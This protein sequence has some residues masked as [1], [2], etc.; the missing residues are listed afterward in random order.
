MQAHIFCYYYSNSRG[1]AD[2]TLLGSRTQTHS[3]PS[4]LSSGHKPSFLSRVFTPRVTLAPSFHPS[5]AEVAQD[6][7]ATV[8]S[9][10]QCSPLYSLSVMP[11]SLLLPLWHCCGFGGLTGRDFIDGFLPSRQHRE[12]RVQAPFPCRPISSGLCSSLW[13]LQ[14]SAVPRLD[15]AASL[16]VLSVWFIVPLSN[17]VSL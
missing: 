12:A 17:R 3:F 13:N 6:S 16:Q 11:A 14:V 5:R 10:A 9:A 15:M 4:W 7:P 2:H 1:R 8:S